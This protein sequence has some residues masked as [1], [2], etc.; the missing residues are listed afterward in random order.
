MKTILVFL[1]LLWTN[2][3]LGQSVEAVKFETKWKKKEIQSIAELQLPKSRQ[4][5]PLLIIQHS[6]GPNTRLSSFNG[7]TDFIGYAVGTAALE[8]GFAV[9]Y[10]DVFTPR[11]IVKDSTGDLGVNTNVAVRDIKALLKVMIKDNRIDKNK[12]YLFG[13]SYGGGTA[14][15]LSYDSTW[16]G[17]NPFKAIVA[18]APGCQVNVESKISTPTKIII[19]EKDDWTP[20]NM[21]VRLV[22]RQKLNKSSV[23][24]EVVKDVNHSYSYSGT[25]MWNRQSRSGCADK[26]VILSE[27]KQITIDGKPLSKEQFK[28]DCIKQG[29][30][31]GGNSEQLSYVVDQ[32][33]GYFKTH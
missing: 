13:H 28:K 15:N 16:G 3:V 31:S 24:I 30:T 22:D 1:T 17:N 26:V 8:N 14:L 18:S 11:N 19:G 6:S 5:V 25:W 2:I 23:E 27:N 7:Y 4:P 12:I 20:A 33:L 10:T 21:C 29:A 32:T 9:I